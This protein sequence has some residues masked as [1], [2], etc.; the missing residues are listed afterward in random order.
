MFLTMIP[1]LQFD[2]WQWVSALI[3][4]PVVFWAA[5][6]FHRV[7]LLNLKHRAVTMDTL[8]SMGVAVSYFWS[9]YAILFTH[10]GN[11]DMKMSTTFIGAA[12]EHEIGIYFEVSVAVT[13]LVILGKFL[14]FRARDKSKQALENLAK[15]KLHYTEDSNDI[16]G[17]NKLI[18]SRKFKIRR[19][20]GKRRNRKKG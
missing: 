2:Y 5:W 11:K 13:T 4:T 10:A 9:V 1:S 20:K 16:T 8:V 14:E 6:P 17:N 7:A 18:F 19:E 3:A 15:N 12:S